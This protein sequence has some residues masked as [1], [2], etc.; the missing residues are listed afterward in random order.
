MSL[1]PLQSPS[2]RVNSSARKQAPQHAVNVCW[3]ERQGLGFRRKVGCPGRH[4]AVNMLA[5]WSFGTEAARALG[6]EQFGAFYLS[7]G[8][9]SGLLSH[10]GRIRSR[11][12]GFSLGA[13]GAVYAC[14][15]VSAITRP[16][17]EVPTCHQPE[18]HF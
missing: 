13:S 14:F 10:L 12:G 18:T 17:T 2:Q 7:A 3:M 9:A 11:S 4:L 5:F 1:V 6:A 8:L 16:D 15:A